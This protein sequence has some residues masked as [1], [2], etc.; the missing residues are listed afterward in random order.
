MAASVFQSVGL[1]KRFY[2]LQRFTSW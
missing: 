1:H 2:S